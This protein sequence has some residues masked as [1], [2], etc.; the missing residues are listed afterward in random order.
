V[1]IPE[2]LDALDAAI[3]AEFD[4]ELNGVTFTNRQPMVTSLRRSLQSTMVDRL[5]AMSGGMNSMPHPIRT[6]STA[7][8]NDVKG[9]IDGVIENGGKGQVDQY[10]MAHLQDMSTRIGKALDTVYVSQN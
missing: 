3:F 4:T 9:R 8:L 6:L 10:T 5:I 1:T 7:R 2:I